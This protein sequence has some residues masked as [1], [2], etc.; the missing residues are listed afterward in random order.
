MKVI[1]TC[2]TFF[3]FSP[4]DCVGAPISSIHRFPLSFTYGLQDLTGF[5]VCSSSCPKSN[6]SYPTSSVFPDASGT[7]LIPRS[8]LVLTREHNGVT[9]FSMELI[10]EPSGKYYYLSVSDVVVLNPKMPQSCSD[11]SITVHLPAKSSS[12]FI[13]LAVMT[14]AIRNRGKVCIRASDGSHLCRLTLL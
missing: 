11:I 14:V 5:I 3:L 7:K 8:S 6:V 13:Q 9:A 1:C 12:P 2:G 10:P 4:G